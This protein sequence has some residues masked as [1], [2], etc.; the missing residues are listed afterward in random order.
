MRIIPSILFKRKTNEDRE[1]LNGL[2]NEHFTSWT[3]PRVLCWILFSSNMLENVI[4]W[5][6]I[7]TWELLVFGSNVN[8]LS[9]YDSEHNFT[10]FFHLSLHTPALSRTAKTDS[11]TPSVRVLLPVGK[12]YTITVT[13][14]LYFIKLLIIKLIAKG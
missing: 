13:V 1:R 5:L 9:A 11:P 7:C 4:C 2:N 6:C 14:L 10:W 3:K 8:L 12:I